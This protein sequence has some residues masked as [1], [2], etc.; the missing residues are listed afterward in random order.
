MRRLRSLQTI[1]TK[2]TKSKKKKVVSSILRTP[3][4][5]KGTSTEITDVKLKGIIDKILR[6]DGCFLKL[7]DPTMSYRFLQFSVNCRFHFS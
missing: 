4:L 1:T 6:E 2:N 3:C 7:Y 5:F